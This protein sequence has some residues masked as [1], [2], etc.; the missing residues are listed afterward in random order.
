MFRPNRQSIPGHPGVHLRDLRRMMGP[1]AIVLFILS[2]QTLPTDLT[3]T[4]DRNYR[5]L[6]YILSNYVSG[7]SINYTGIRE[8]TEPLHR[9]IRGMKNLTR[10]EFESLSR[11][12]RLA[13]LI[14]A[15]NAYA[16]DA[17][18]G[19]WP[20]RSD[21]SIRR[22]RKRR[23]I[24]LIG[25][26]WSLQSLND[27][28]MNYPYTDSR[29]FVML[30][31][32]ARGCPGLPPYALT[33]SNLE[34]LLEM[35]LRHFFSDPGQVHHDDRGHVLSISSLFLEYLKP[36]ERDY[37]TLRLFLEHYLPAEIQ[38]AV[39][40]KRPRIRYFPF[41]GTPAGAV[42]HDASRP[43]RIVNDD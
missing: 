23:N 5:G 20:V 2:C 3:G 24:V 35:Q 26:R 10:D 25:R 36:I 41:E 40:S 32:G 4:F 13:F 7:K 8:D 16:L 22:I 37:T 12:S 34:E 14:N 27:H 15:H 42:E 11:K 21:S 33:G 18:A 9:S 17:V 38:S 29:A 43:D 39:R 1:A 30:N 28:L 6:N 19:S 31:W